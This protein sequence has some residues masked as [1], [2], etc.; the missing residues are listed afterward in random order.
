MSDST[1]SPW[2]HVA[3]MPDV[4][5]DYDDDLPSGDAWW[6]PA[7]RVILIATGLTQIERRCAL[8]HELVHIEND[9]QQLDGPDSERI[10]RRRERAAEHTAARRL[11]HL[12]DLM[13]ALAWCM[14][15]EEVA[16]ELHVDRALLDT[17]LELL[18]AEDQEIIRARFAG[19]WNVC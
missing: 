18:D 9:D 16:E 5:I 3:T 13:D 2:R 12:D 14:S 10:E 11:I 8:A 7:H 19:E 17:R 6:S 4:V 15:L 1:Y